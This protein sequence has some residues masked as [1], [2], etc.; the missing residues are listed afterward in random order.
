MASGSVAASVVPDAVIA[1]YRIG[2]GLAFAEGA[3]QA[4]R[5]FAKPHAGVYA[6]RDFSRN[7]WLQT[8]GTPKEAVLC[9]IAAPIQPAVAGLGHDSQS[10]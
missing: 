4:D 2:Y 10:L 1:R 6:T 9:C 3:A 5:Q 7:R 8:V